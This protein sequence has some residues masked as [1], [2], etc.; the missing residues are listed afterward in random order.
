MKRQSSM[1][2]PCGSDAGID[3]FTPLRQVA[4]PG[5]A[6]MSPGSFPAA[7]VSPYGLWFGGAVLTI[8]LSIMTG[9]HRPEHSVFITPEP[10]SKENGKKPGAQPLPVMALGSSGGETGGIRSVAVSVCT[11]AQ[12]ND[13]NSGPVGTQVAVGMVGSAEPHASSLLVASCWVS[14]SQ[15]IS[16]APAIGALDASNTPR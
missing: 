9:A 11:D 16:H 14:G 10:S 4:C 3:P 12:A 13:L 6:F 1:S 8:V 5:T 7:L 2:S 15:P